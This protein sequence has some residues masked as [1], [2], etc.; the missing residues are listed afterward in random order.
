M[1]DTHSARN[2]AVLTYTGHRSML[3]GS[4]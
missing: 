1:G 2:G 4:L 3:S